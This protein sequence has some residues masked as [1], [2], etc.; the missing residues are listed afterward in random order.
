ME[1]EQ[2][3][4]P[5]ERH[6]QS[7]K[8]ITGFGIQAGVEAIGHVSGFLVND[9]NWSIEQLVVETGHWYSGKEILIS[10]ALV[11]RISYDESKIYVTITKSDIQRIKE[12]EPSK[13]GSGIQDVEERPAIA[14]MQTTSA[15]RA[16]STAFFK[17]FESS[18]S[19]TA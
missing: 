2:H 8:S 6:L 11:E 4:H 17:S 15:K 19:A 10:P 13:A 14:M 5:A 12:E 18:L 16:A 3:P 7:T 1:A 9:K